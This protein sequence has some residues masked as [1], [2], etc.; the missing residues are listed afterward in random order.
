MLD[1]L[2]DMGG[3]LDALYFICAIVL[4]PLGRYALKSQLINTMFRYRKSDESQGLRRT[5]SAVHQTF[6]RRFS[7][8]MDSVEDENVLLNNIKHDF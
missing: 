6:R 8:S 3:L 4:T 5:N 1:W 7:A 2:G